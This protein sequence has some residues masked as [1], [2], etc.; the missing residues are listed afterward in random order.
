M[1]KWFALQVAATAPENAAARAEAL[2]KRPDF[3]WK[4]PN[5]FR[6]V[7]GSL[8]M[9]HAGFHAKDGR[10][11]RLLADW[12]IKLDEKNPQTT[13]RMCSVF[14]TWKRYDT[15]RQAMMKAELQRIADRPGL[16]RDVTEMVTRLLS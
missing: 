3:D 7:M 12:L 2:T 6:A 10:G 8:A 16:S 4:N 1:D 5:R 14:Q 15:D 9:N 11:Y 13:A